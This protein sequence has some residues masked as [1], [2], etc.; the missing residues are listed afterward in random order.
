MG[1][2]G[3]AGFRLPAY[4]NSDPAGRTD[5]KAV[6]DKPVTLFIDLTYLLV[7]TYLPGRCNRSS[8]APST[9]IHVHILYQQG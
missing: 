6:V 4:Q 3:I 2:V 5:R 7:P 9:Y 8:E 1:K